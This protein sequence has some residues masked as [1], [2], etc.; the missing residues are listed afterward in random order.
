MGTDRRWW[1]LAGSARHWRA[2]VALAGSD[3]DWLSLAATDGY[4]LPLLATFDE[5]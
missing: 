2:P 3:G 1:T 5:L 4:R